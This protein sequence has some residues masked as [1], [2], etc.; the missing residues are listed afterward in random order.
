VDDQ[1]ALTESL[2][3]FV[4]GDM[5]PRTFEHR[6]CTTPTLESELGPGLYMRAI[7]A[8]YGKPEEV[9]AVRNGVEAFLVTSRPAACACLEMRDLQVVPRGD[10]ERQFRTIE[11]VKRHGDPLWWLPALAMRSIARALRADPRRVDRD[12]LRPLA[13]ANPPS[14]P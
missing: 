3:R 4:R 13:V 14:S 1:D 12:T 6:V 2:W 5:E 7:S 9:D 8:A 10:H 11:V